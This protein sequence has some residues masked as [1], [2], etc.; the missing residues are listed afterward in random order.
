MTREGAFSVALTGGVASGKSAAA[1]SFAALGAHVLDADVVARELVEPG[2]AALRA[3]TAEFGA[4]VLDDAGS[5]D[6]GAMRARVFGDADARA[7][8]EAILHPRIRAVL[9]ER[10][11]AIRD[12]YC[13]LVIPLLVE[14]GAYDWVDR[15]LVVDVP[16][17]VQLA[18]LI[19]RDGIPMHRAESM[20]AAQ[21]SR[22]A[23][24][25]IADDI[26]D[27][28]GPPASL[29]AQVASLHA[30]YQDLA[31]KRTGS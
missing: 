1:R 15:V 18:R 20:L 26:I 19:E 11:S 7:R 21:A 5:L 12:G 27:N 23:R 13:L 14:S 10:S 30:R 4:A 24:L 8:L 3:I 2:G 16:R 17:E 31:R 29:E 6:R 9:R 25:A 22:E 28:S